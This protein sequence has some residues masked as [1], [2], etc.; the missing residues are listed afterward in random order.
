[1]A[2]EL[3]DAWGKKWNKPPSELSIHMGTAKKWD[4]GEK[5]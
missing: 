2:N 4:S 3:T 5:K 1:M